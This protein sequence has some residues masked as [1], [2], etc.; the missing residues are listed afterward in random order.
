MNWLRVLPIRP[1]ASLILARYRQG[2]LSDA[3]HGWISTVSQVA[4]YRGPNLRLVVSFIDVKM[5][6]DPLEITPVELNTLQIGEGSNRVFNT[7]P[8]RLL[9]DIWECRKN[10]FRQ[11]SE[12]A[13]DLAKGIG[14]CRNVLD[15]RDAKLLP[16]PL[17]RLSHFDRA[18]LEE[19]GFAVNFIVQ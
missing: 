17:D 12:V 9:C 10:F 7:D 16:K 11:R 3:P 5:V 13:R 4:Q 2:I 1:R 15:Q 19:L 14:R 6:K 18:A 8:V